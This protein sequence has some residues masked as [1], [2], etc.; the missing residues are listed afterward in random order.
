MDP[1]RSKKSKISADLPK[2]SLTSNRMEPKAT[3]DAF[4]DALI[5]FGKSHPSVVIVDCDLATATKTDKFRTAFPDR[6]FQLG[7]QEANAIGAGAGLANSGFRPFVC[8]FACFITGR[9]DQ[10]RISVALDNAPAVIVGTHGGL[11]IGK[12]GATQMGLEDVNL[13]RGMPNMTVLQPADYIETIEMVKYLAETRNPA[14]LR[15]GRQPLPHINKEGYKFQFGKGITLANGNDLAIVA[16]GGMV[17][18][19]LEVAKILAEEGIKARVINI[20]TLKPI[21][22]KIILKAAKETKGIFTLEDHNV[23]GGLGSAVA[24]IVAE[25]DLATPVKRWGIQDVF[26]ESGDPKDLYRKHEL[27]KEGILKNV[28]KFYKKLK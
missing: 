16:T 5:R 1:I 9:Y 19:A 27:D 10:I 14:Y 8:S 21:D 11:A 15:L 17:Y 12:D 23:Y 24:E 20:H 4:G 7:I 3:R 26:G 22:E 18:I 28:R 2:I 6:F 13:M 25:S